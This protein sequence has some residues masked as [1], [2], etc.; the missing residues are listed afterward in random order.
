[1]SGTLGH[2]QEWGHPPLLISS[3]CSHLFCYSSAWKLPASQT[4]TFPQ[5]SWFPEFPEGALGWEEAGH[6]EG[7]WC[8]GPKACPTPQ[9]HCPQ[10]S[11]ADHRQDQPSVEGREQERKR[12]GRRQRAGQPCA[13]GVCPWGVSLPLVIVSQAPWSQ[14]RMECSYHF[15]ERRLSSSFTKML[16][17][18]IR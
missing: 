8:L 18:I 5:E 14:R 13:Q 11:L 3:Y 7:P 16:S 17:F 9:A 6:T 2:P 15:P 12:R 10:L 4:T 1:M